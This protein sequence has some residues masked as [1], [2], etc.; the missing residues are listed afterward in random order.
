MGSDRR[1]GGRHV[2][3]HL[4]KLSNYKKTPWCNHEKFV[5]NTTTQGFTTSQQYPENSTDSNVLLATNQPSRETSQMDLLFN[6]DAIIHEPSEDERFYV[7]LSQRMNNFITTFNIFVFFLGSLINFLVIFNRFQSD[8]DE[9]QAFDKQ[10]VRRASSTYGSRGSIDKDNSVSTRIQLETQ[11]RIKQKNYIPGTYSSKKLAT[12]RGTIDS[13][14]ETRLYVLMSKL[15]LEDPLHTYLTALACCTIFIL[16]PLPFFSITTFLQE[17]WIFGKLCC[18]VIPSMMDIGKVL[19]PLFVATIAVHQVF[20]VFQPKKQNSEPNSII[21]TIGQSK[22]EKSF[23]SVNSSKLI[24]TI[25]IVI[26]MFFSLPT[27]AMNTFSK[28]IVYDEIEGRQVTIY[29]CGKVP[30]GNTMITAGIAM[31]FSNFISSFLAVVSVGLLKFKLKNEFFDCFGCKNKEIRQEIQIEH[32]PNRISAKEKSKTIDR[33]KKEAK[34][35]T[36]QVIKLLIIFLICWLPNLTTNMIYLENMMNCRSLS[37]IASQVLGICHKMTQTL[38]ISYCVINPV[39][40][41]NKGGF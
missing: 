36:E 22:R 33:A 8:E 24:S 27:I 13:I 28:S 9:T 23:Y 3:T 18:Y 12:R 37:S 11:S 32:F 26:G 10:A 31:G 38:F 15:T 21:P 39:L 1:M 7:T 5:Q 16:L 34:K 19:C 14:K 20:T 30:V 2:V 25:V 17:K 6:T 40:V 4:H 41:A 35:T 29:T